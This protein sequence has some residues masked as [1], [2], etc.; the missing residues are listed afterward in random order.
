MK[1]RI[2]FPVLVFVVAPVQAAR[3]EPVTAWRGETRTMILHDHV[4]VG[5]APTGLEV[6]VGVAKDVRYL[7]RPFGTHYSSFADRVVWGSPDLGVKVLSV[8]ASPDAK[9]GVYL[10]GDV[11]VTVLDRLLP[12]ASE[13]KYHL[14]LWQHPWAVARWHGVKPFSAAHYAAMRPLW[15][16]LA[17]AGQKAL[18]VTL[19]DLPWNHQCY[20]AY[21]SMV[22]RIKHAD[23]SWTFDYSILDEYVAFGRSCGICP[24]IACYT[25][26][27]WEY[28]V[29]WQD[30][31]GAWQG[32]KA[33]P[34][35]PEFKAYW[36]T[37]LTDFERHVRE[38][39]WLGDVY[40]ALDERS[41]EDVV[42]VANFIREKAPGL[43][44]SL[45]G[46]RSP[47]QFKGCRIDHCCFGL[48]RLTDELI[49]EADDRRSKGMLTTYYV[50]CAPDYPNTFCSSEIEEAFWLGAYPAFAG[51]D[52]FLRWA[53]NSWPQD[54]IRDASYTGIKTGW[55]SGDTYLVYPDGAPSLR[56]LELRNGIVAAEK[57]RILRESGDLSRDFETLKTDFDRHQAMSNKTD[58]VALRAKVLHLVNK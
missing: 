9:P 54:P 49:A 35:S 46:N 30:E 8:S 52:G 45:A 20:D 5:E 57:V 32:V 42:N 58:F 33:V 16:M 29:R 28:E 40:I 43:K 56:F 17:G 1:M 4:F 7:D 12:P 31:S 24:E 2:L 53:W 13:W 36:G 55:K 21:H 11:E 3:L 48:K 51:L 10:C 23:G 26:C 18:T 22:G 50:C 38:K 6:R 34:G 41:P 39:G 44:L 25:M 19:I 47:S 27:P 37:F 15:T 14:D